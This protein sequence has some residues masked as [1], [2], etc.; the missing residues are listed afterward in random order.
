MEW[1]A[2]KLKI[3]IQYEKPVADEY[4]QLK[5]LPRIDET[6]RITELKEEILPED[7][8]VKKR[9]DDAK[10]QYVLG[11]MAK[12][13]REFSYEAEGTV[14]VQKYNRKPENHEMLYQISSPYT[15]VGQN[16][17][18]WYGE[19]NLPEGEVRDR[20]LWIA[21]FV[22]R[23][24]KKREEAEKEGLLTAD[25]AAGRGYGS[26]RDFA[27]IMLALCHM[28]G[29]TARYVTGILPGKTSL[30]SW[31]E[32]QGEDGIFYGMDPE[33]GIPVTESY[34]VFC[35]G[36]DAKECSLL[37]S[38]SAGETG[39]TMEVSGVRKHSLAGEKNGRPEQFLPEHPSGPPEPCHEQPGVYD[40]LCLERSFRPGRGRKPSLCEG[41]FPV[42]QCSGGK[43]FPDLYKT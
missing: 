1:I 25:Q 14:Q 42:A 28:D 2:Y 40:S 32:V 26:N 24:L 10:N 8:M 35:Q 16:L 30:H 3:K 20:A 36:R 11:Y 21:G 43:T 12:P 17:G 9:M 41:H 5:C 38:G 37:V 18:E 15:E 13:H 27:Q 6:Q 31:V 39:R 22:K 7:C 4:F 34:V 33:F 19:L 29:I 23:K